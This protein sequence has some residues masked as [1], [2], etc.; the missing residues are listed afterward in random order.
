MAFEK[1]YEVRGFLWSLLKL[2][3]FQSATACH[4]QA[5]K[6]MIRKLNAEQALWDLQGCI[7][8][9]V[10]D[11]SNFENWLGEFFNVN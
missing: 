6:S 5:G 1:L 11:V 4:E 3:S 10:E 8:A 2:D 9:E 7:K